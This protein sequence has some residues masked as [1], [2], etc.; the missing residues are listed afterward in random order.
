[1]TPC[2]PMAAVAT[3]SKVSSGSE[4]VHAPSLPP[5]VVSGIFDGKRKE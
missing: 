3:P 1:M 5:R 4:R 2:T